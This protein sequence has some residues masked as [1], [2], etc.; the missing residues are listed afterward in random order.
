MNYYDFEIYLSWVDNEGVSVYYKSWDLSPENPEPYNEGIFNPESSDPIHITEL[1]CFGKKI[2]KLLF[3]TED[4]R[5]RFRSLWQKKGAVRL[6]LIYPDDNNSIKKLSQ[7]LWEYAYFPKYAEDENKNYYLLGINSDI[8][9]VHSIKQIAPSPISVS[10]ERLPV[11]M[12]YF[13]Y[14]GQQS[15][16]IGEDNIIFKEFLEGY[17]KLTLLLHCSNITDLEHPSIEANR[18]VQPKKQDV[19]TAV[20]TD[21]LILLTGHCETTKI[22]LG[23]DEEDNVISIAELEN[24]FGASKDIDLKAIILTCCNSADGKSV[25]TALHRLGVPVAIGMSRTIIDPS[26]MKDFVVGFFQALATWPGDGLERAIIEARKTIFNKED[27]L[28]QHWPAGYGLPRLFLNGYNSTLIPEYLLFGSPEMMINGFRNNIRKVGESSNDLEAADT[29]PSTDDFLPTLI[30]WIVKEEAAWYLITGP[31]GTGKTTLIERLLYQ[32]IVKKQDIEEEELP[33]DL[34]IIYHFCQRENASTSDP[35]EVVRHSWVPQLVEHYGEDYKQAIPEG[36]FPLLVGNE[37]VAMRVFVV[38]PLR[39]LKDKLKDKFTPPVF[40]IDDLTVI[41]LNYS[42]LD[43][44]VDNRGDL[45]DIARFIITANEEETGFLG[46]EATEDAQKIIEDIYWLTNNHQ[47]RQNYMPIEIGDDPRILFKKM[48][49]RLSSIF[50]AEVSYGYGA[51]LVEYYIKKWPQLFELFDEAIE[52][53]KKEDQ[54]PDWWEEKVNRLLN[55]VTITYEP[56]YISNI[57]T[58]LNVDDSQIDE[59]KSA[60]WPF[61]KDYENYE[62]FSL[63]HGSLKAYRLHKM[64]WWNKKKRDSL[65]DTHEFFVNAFHS[66]PEENWAEVTNWKTLAGT[67]WPDVTKN[68]DKDY[69]ASISRYARRYLVYHA[70]YSCYYTSWNKLSKRRERAKVFLNLICNSEFRNA[71]LYEVGQR[72]ALQDIW[73]GLR[74][75]IVEYIHAKGGK[76]HKKTRVA[77]DRL[78]AA[79]QPNTYRRHK[80]IQLEKRLRNDDAGWEDLFEFLNFDT[81]Q[82]RGW[83]DD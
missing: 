7:I 55:I 68:K 3:P 17:S 61:F 30:D 81:P 40:I 42:V 83:W 80:L 43:L 15:G 23:S 34:K 51:S 13:T 27:D 18:A 5:N 1:Y 41:D 45:E 11:G 78:L 49:E 25:A 60:L 52:K 14:W 28:P 59:L 76:N 16:D 70:Y 75:I 63:Y 26:Q 39:Q 69:L 72:T 65:A 67:Q 33:E 53:V 46:V 54:K 9:I 58:I 32:L 77:F 48:Q 10:V 73:L 71:R 20:Q 37:K 47:D 35:L 22:T 66:Q 44:L 4:L 79:E 36:K 12:K 2:T 64:S 8:S 56:L 74:I 38:E 6:R 29:S 19:I 57:A 31:S 50:P 24:L 21:H 62:K 82:E